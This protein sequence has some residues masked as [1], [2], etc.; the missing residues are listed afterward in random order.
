MASRKKVRR[1][2][3]WFI[4]D[5]RQLV[6]FVCPKPVGNGVPTEHDGELQRWSRSAR[7]ALAGTV[8]GTDTAA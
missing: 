8:Q 1:K 4:T 5:H 7:E 3:D 6:P 2:A